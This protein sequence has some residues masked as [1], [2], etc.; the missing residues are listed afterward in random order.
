MRQEQE[1]DLLV[2]SPSPFR[3]RFM[4]FNKFIFNK[5]YSIP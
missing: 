3:K 2:L 1:E 5:K 4:E